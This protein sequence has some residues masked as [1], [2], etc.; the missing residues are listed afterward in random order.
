[1]TQ[2]A[3]VE[4]PNINQGPR[5]IVART[6]GGVYSQDGQQDIIDGDA[7][8]GPITLLSGTT[9]AIAPAGNIVQ[10]NSQQQ[11]VG[12]NY[13]IKT[14]SA[15]AITI[16]APTAGVDDGLNV[17]IWSDTAFAH[18]VTAPSAIFATGQALH[19]I[20]TFP[21]FRGAGMTLRAFNGTWQVVGV[22]V[23]Q[24]VFSA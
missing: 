19:S 14:G 2:I 17:N 9:D 21:A 7:F 1:M 13:I 23:G 20:A 16:S 10:P 3:V 4:I 15:D 22:S 18:T 6:V 12:G 5:G 24:P 8:Q 11:H